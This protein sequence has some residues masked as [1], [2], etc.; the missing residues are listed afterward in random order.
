[1]ASGA[2]V[3]KRKE[4][5]VKAPRAAYVKKTYSPEFLAEQEAIDK[6]VR[7]EGAKRIRQSVE[8]LIALGIVDKDGNRLKKELPADMLPGADRD[9]GG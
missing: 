7:E 2:A 8:K 4:S 6:R 5:A 3:Q 9:F 1:M